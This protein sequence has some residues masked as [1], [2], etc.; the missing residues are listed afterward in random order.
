MATTRLKELAQQVANLTRTT[1][2]KDYFR[3][4]VIAWEAAFRKRMMEVEQFES[5]RREHF[6]NVVT[7]RPELQRLDAG[8]PEP[9]WEWD[10]T[11]LD[12]R[13]KVRVA[14]IVAWVP[15]ELA[16]SARPDTELPSPRLSRGLD[17]DEQYA[18]L[19]AVHDVYMTGVERIDPWHP[20]SDPASLV[21]ARYLALLH[22]VKADDVHW[23][24]LGRPAND[25]NDEDAGNVELYLKKVR[26]DLRSIR[27]LE[28]DK[29]PAVKPA[30]VQ[31]ARTEGEEQPTATDSL[32]GEEKALALLVAH[33]D[34][35][36]IKI[37]EKTPCSRTTLYGW[38]KYVAVRKALKA[39][40]PKPLRGTKDGETGAVEAWEG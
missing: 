23:Q 28:A 30:E 2:L 37:A 20:R 11:F 38:S 4:R 35:T 12:E 5:R 33:P 26:D 29:S 36:D 24:D 25:L 17:L 3:E 40:R 21:G 10:N 31:S 9:G 39:N 32:T 14:V 13:V 34:W 6:E 15:P 16:E 8:R 1:T 7:M 27:L 18:L 19:A 22:V